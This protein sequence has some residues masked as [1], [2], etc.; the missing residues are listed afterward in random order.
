MSG[1]KN[2]HIKGMRPRPRFM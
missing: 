1:F 2:N